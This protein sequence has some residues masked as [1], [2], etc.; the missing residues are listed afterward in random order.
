MWRVVGSTIATLRDV[1]TRQQPFPRHR[2][3]DQCIGRGDKVAPTARARELAQFAVV[4][5]PKGNGKSAAFGNG[6]TRP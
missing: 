4:L 2:V 3:K 1:N 5:R 6:A